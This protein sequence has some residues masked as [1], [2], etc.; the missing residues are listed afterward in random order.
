VLTGAFDPARFYDRDYFQ[1]AH[2]DGYGDYIGSEPVL[3]REF[4]S[5]L[6]RLR[7]WAPSGKLLEVGCAYGFFLDEARPHFQCVGVEVAQDAVVQCTQ[8]GLD[9][10]RGDLAE[11]EALRQQVQGRAPFAAAVM[12]DCIE[13][14]ARPSRVVETIAA[15]LAPGGALLLTTGDFGSLPARL[16]GQRWRLMTPPQHLF[17]FTRASLYAM[18]SRHGLEVVECRAPW[19]LVPLGLA[20]YQVGRRVGVP[21]RAFEALG[22]VGVPVNLFDTVSVVAVKR[23]PAA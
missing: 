23:P 21:M 12:L 7:R 11:D 3:R 14:L 9:V 19:K 20:A 5:A 6:G 18:L 16:L 10:L 1:G 4:R 15:S 2:K 22:T 13:H 8:R 17:Y